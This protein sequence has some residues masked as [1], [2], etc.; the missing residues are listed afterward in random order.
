MSQAV[1]LEA[2][3]RLSQF[4]GGQSV[5]CQKVSCVLARSF[6]LAFAREVLS[7]API[8]QKNLSTHSRIEYIPALSP[9][10]K[11]GCG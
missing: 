9:R 11:G 3:P 6:A 7:T 5:E 10:F 1:F 2:Q 8:A 4:M